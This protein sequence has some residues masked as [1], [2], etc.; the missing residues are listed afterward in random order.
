M[1]TS[2]SFNKWSMVVQAYIFSILG[3]VVRWS[4]V[5][6]LTTKD[7]LI[8]GETASKWKWLRRVA[9]IKAKVDWFHME[10][11]ATDLPG[12]YGGEHLHISLVFGGN[13]K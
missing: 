4:E 12:L 5:R 1:V 13:S 8:I 7:C 6:E 11:R 2:W 3:G 10:K 9:Q